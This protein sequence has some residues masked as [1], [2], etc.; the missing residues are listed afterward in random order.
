MQ[1]YLYSARDESGKVIKGE[2]LAESEAELSAKI[3]KLGYFLTSIKLDKSKSKIKSHSKSYRI[4][5]GEVLR[6]TFQLAT[7]IDAGMPLLESLKDLARESTD[8]KTQAILDDIR[9]RVESGDTLEGAL[10]YHQESFSPLFRALIGAGEATGRLSSVLHDLTNLLE[11]QAEMLSRIKEASMYPIILCTVM[12]G[13]VVLLVVKVI[14]MFTPIFESLDSALPLPTQIVVTSSYMLRTYWY[15]IVIVVTLVV[16]GYKVFAASENGRFKIDQYK[17]RLPLV[18]ELN[19]KIALSRF[20]H[21]FALSFRSGINLLSC[22]DIA[23]RTTGNVCIEKA[24][25]KARD[26]VN[27]GEK[28]GVSLQATGEF[29]A[30]VVRMISIGEQ[31]GALTDTLMKVAEFY[32]KEVASMIRRL[33]TAFEPIMIVT[34][35]IV[36]GGIALA[37]FMPMFQMV[38]KMG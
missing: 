26:A 34:M 8:E 27:V 3:S 28:L 38:D 14:P 24:I 15:I 30:M 25:G 5:G 31:S 29:P 4:K 11:W 10:S 9:Y 2:M 6:F 33:F 13:V 18:G 22:L 1:K 35:G 19:R 37:I 7:L 36:V 16:V 23:K 32:D 17:L 21:T 12:V 20:S